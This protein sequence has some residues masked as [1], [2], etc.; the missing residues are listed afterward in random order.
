MAPLV[1]PTFWRGRR[2]FLTGHTGFKGSWLALLLEHLGAVVTGY[3]I[4]V[5]TTPSFYESARVAEGIESVT[6]DIRVVAAVTRAM[7]QARPQVVFHLAAQSLVRRSH[8]EPVETFTTNVLGTANVLEA[9]R[10][11]DGIRSVVVATSDKCYRRSNTAH[12]EDD[13]LGGEDP[14]SASKAA[15]ELVA[16]AYRDSYFSADGPALATVRAGNV[17]GGGDWARDRLVPDVM[18]A[19]LDGGTVI[20]RN[21]GHVRPWQHVLGPLS[22]YLGLAERLEGDR[23]FATAWNFGP[24]EDEARPVESIVDA[25]VER[26]PTTVA[27]SVEDDSGGAREADALRLDSSRARELLGWRTWPLNTALD[28]TAEWYRAFAAGEDVRSVALAQIARYEAEMNR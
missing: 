8:E 25:L 4:D 16:A 12:S 6:G 14:Y 9:V 23:G 13:P 17:I 15:A 26:W 21:P 19:A 24:A 7:E 10:G 20:V 2:V 11:V 22:G 18:R 1:S 28:A 27:I 3:A 5:P